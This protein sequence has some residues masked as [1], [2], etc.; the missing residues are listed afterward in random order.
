MSATN[1]TSKCRIASIG[2]DDAMILPYDANSGPDHI[3]GK[4]R[5]QAALFLWRPARAPAE[6]AHEWSQSTVSSAQVF[7]RPGHSANTKD[8]E[9]NTRRLRARSAYTARTN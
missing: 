2:P 7:G 6:I 9:R 8:S 3:F 4:D 5:G 1:I